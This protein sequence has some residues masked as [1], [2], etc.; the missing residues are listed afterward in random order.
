MRQRCGFEA[1][2]DT[3]CREALNPVQHGTPLS[4]ST[5]ALYPTVAVAAAH[6]S[7]TLGCISVDRGTGRLIDSNCFNYSAV[8]SLC[9]RI[10][11]NDQSI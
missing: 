7:A 1:S 9:A 4:G 6:R 11:P 5:V 3:N 10:E 8:Q 2:F